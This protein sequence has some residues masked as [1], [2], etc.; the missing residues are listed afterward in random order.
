MAMTNLRKECFAWAIGVVTG[1]CFGF[2]A[3]VYYGGWQWQKLAIRDGVGQW[4]IDPQ[5]GER[6][7]EWVSPDIA[8]LRP[9]Q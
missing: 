7:F 2:T 8:N 6:R 3:G 5:T 4:A 1:L 9:P